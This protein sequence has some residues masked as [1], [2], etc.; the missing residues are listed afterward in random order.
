MTAH[1]TT[2]TPAAEP[3]QQHYILIDCWDNDQ[4]ITIPT[5]CR[6]ER[7]YRWF[8]RDR[9]KALISRVQ[10]DYASMSVTISLKNDTLATADLVTV[11]IKQEDEIDGL[12]VID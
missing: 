11:G 1:L 6:L 9:Y 3:G 8:D 5:G 4:E 10:T 7:E 2:H 12:F